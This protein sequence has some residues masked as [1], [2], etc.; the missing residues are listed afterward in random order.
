[1]AGVTERFLRRAIQRERQRRAVPMAQVALN[2]QSLAFDQQIA[3]ILDDSDQSVALCGRRAGK[4]SAARLLLVK[5]ALEKPGSISAIITPTRAD[6][7]KLYWASL[8]A[9]LRR[10]GIWFKLV[11]Q[12]LVIKFANG[13]E[14]WLGGAK[15]ATQIERFRGHAFALVI[16]D[17]AQA[18]REHMLRILVEE[19][20]QWALVDYAGK[21]RVLGTPPHV[22]VGWFVERYTGKDDK[23]R[24]V[25]GW[26]RHHWTIFDNRLM[27]GGDAAVL[28]WLKKRKDEGLSEQSA[29]WRREVLGELVLDTDQLVLSAF[30]L[31]LSV[32]EPNELPAGRPTTV[33]GIDV[34]WQHSDAIVN[35]GRYPESN[36]L[37]VV[38]EWEKNHQTEE[39]LGERILDVSSRW[40]P[41]RRVIDTGGNAKTAAG[42]AQRIGIDY[43]PANKPGII[44]QFARVNDE[45]RARGS[46]G[47]SRLRVPKGGYCA[48]DAVR[49]AWAPGKIGQ[50]VADEPHSNVL[51]ALAYAMQVASRY[52]KPE[53]DRDTP[54][55]PE[56]LAERARLAAYN[57]TQPRNPQ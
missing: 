41:I 35:V 47:Y 55:T 48:N 22:P 9:L 51:P 25:R 24:D 37:W 15:D 42:I 31:V 27:P 46:R 14:I 23:G 2:L 57:Q 29:T 53:P 17:E 5:T 19:V 26:S 52:F 50:K 11:G 32:Y 33:Q 43:E 20:L 45:F 28:K 3:F 38:E 39:Q 12:D 21:L 18:F 8:Q 16:I 6:T 44:I 4:S 56:E 7:K 13:S 40:P 34:G 36:D 30:D 1:V 10:L 49:L 54:L